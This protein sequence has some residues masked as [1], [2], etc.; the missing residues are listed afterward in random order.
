LAAVE[1]CGSKMVQNDVYI[2][3]YVTYTLL[4]IYF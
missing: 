3:L 1:E 2:L 4:N